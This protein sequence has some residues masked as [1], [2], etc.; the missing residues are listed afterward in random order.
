M[1]RSAVHDACSK[2]NTTQ[3]QSQ[4]ATFQESVRSHTADQFNN[5]STDITDL[6]ISSILRP[7]D[8][9]T[10]LKDKETAKENIQV[11]KSQR[12]RLLTQAKTIKEEAS[13][14]AA[15]SV[16]KAQSD[17]RVALTKAEADAAAITAAFEAEAESYA[18]V[19]TN[20]KLGVEGLL[21]YLSTRVLVESKKDVNIGIDAPAKTKYTYT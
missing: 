9:E 1:A 12:P 6:Q 11:A 21:A 17:A 10:A 4:R 8:Y 18:L 13:A 5:V 3:F 20:Q 14:Q 19:M 2:F 7:K 15:I 16:E